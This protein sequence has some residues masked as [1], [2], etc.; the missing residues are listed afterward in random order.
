MIK[1]EPGQPILINV[2]ERILEL[3][4]PLGELKELAREHQIN[5]LS[6]N[7]MLEVLT[8]PGQ[9]ATVLYYGLKAR[10]PDVTLAWVESNVDASMLRSLYPLLAY[11]A[12]GRWRTTDDD[13]PAPNP[14]PPA[15]R[16]TGSP[17]G[18]S[19]VTTLASANSNSGN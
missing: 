8:D 7:G 13:E 6:G 18:P 14:T 2:G 10:Q 15:T 17:S 5:I 11:A 1:P 19:D 9:L 3:K 12:T 16:S 4:Y